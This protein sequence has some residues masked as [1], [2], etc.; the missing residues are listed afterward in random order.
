MNI[1]LPIETINRELDFKLV[2]AGYLAGQGHQIYLGQHDFL[3]KLVPLIREGGLYIGKNIFNADADKEKGEKYFFLKKN[4]FDVIYLN[5]EG[6]VFF[7]GEENMKIRLNKLY[8][9][10]FFD[11]N[12]QVCVWGDLQK[13]IEKQRSNKVK[14]HNTGHPRFDLCKKEW[15]TLYESKVNT[16][17]S[18]YE[19][20]I[21]INGNFSTSN[22]GYGIENLF[23]REIIEDEKKRSNMFNTF[24]FQSKQLISMIN[25]THKLAYQFPKLNFVYR[26]HPSEDHNYYKVLFK[27]VKN[28]HVEHDGNVI[29][30]ILACKLL[31]HDG[32]TTA[33]EATLAGKPVVNYKSNFDPTRDIWLPNQMGIQ[34]NNIDEIISYIKKLDSDNLNFLSY[35]NNEEVLECLYNFKGNSYEEFLK[36][37]N[38]KN[39][40]NKIN[41]RVPSLRIR[42][43]FLQQSIRDFLIKILKPHKK[44]YLKYHST[45]FYGFFKNDIEE[46]F[47]KISKQLKKNINFKFYNSHLISI[48]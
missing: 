31:L 10:D 37:I 16:I 35:P 32:C 23:S 13:K 4:N 2:L 33:I 40:K 25:L 6:A 42:Q 46:K 8:N 44:K 14:I 27:G 3:M 30:W 29:P 47:G 20:F 24:V 18:V 34:L 28:I 48:E 15:H 7:K 26:P 45:K 38:I 22:P 21:L 41:S 43:F 11:E 12:D 17:R 1:L 5:E 39:D 19:N 9:L 36:I